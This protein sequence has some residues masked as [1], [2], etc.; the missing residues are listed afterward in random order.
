M[1]DIK[2]IIKTP[3]YSFDETSKIDPNKFQP[4]LNDL[5]IV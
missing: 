3:P 5:A 4:S 1:F 2:N